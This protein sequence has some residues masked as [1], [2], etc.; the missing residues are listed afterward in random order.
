VRLV[1]DTWLRALWRVQ[2]RL[3]FTSCGPEVVLSEEGALRL[4]A[5]ERGQRLATWCWA[6][7]APAPACIH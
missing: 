1:G 6:A 5:A 2:S 3:V 4:R 7:W